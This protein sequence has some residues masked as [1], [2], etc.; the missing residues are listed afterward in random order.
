MPDPSLNVAGDTKEDQISEALSM[1]IANMGKM[2]RTALGWESKA[3]FLELH[4]SK[5]DYSGHPS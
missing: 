1:S 3:A 2:K 4:K 5:R